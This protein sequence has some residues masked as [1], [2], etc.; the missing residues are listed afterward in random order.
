MKVT[1][2]GIRERVHE[3]TMEL[4]DRRG[5]K[6]WNMD[7][8]AADAGLA[9]NTLY[10]I[11]GSKEDL[12]REI[13]LGFIRGVQTRLVE[14]IERGDDYEGTLEALLMEFPRLLYG[15]RPDLIREIFLEYPVTQKA[16][17]EHQDEITRSI[18]KFIR[19][20]IEK[21]IL[22]GD[23]TPDFIFELLQAVVLYY[24]GSGRG[25]DEVAERIRLSF[26]CILGGVKA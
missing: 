12:I 8:L 5:L 13:L 20:G 15:V 24:I 19:E 3:K 2:E 14:I 18:L 7:R 17:R 23:I 4:L 26:T 9:K 25:S 10:K 16:V 6:G 1:E 21:G 11:I 22:R